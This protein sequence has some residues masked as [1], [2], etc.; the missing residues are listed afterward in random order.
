MHRTLY[1]QA[2]TEVCGV[3]S[4][5]EREKLVTPEGIA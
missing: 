5:A 1:S 3:I 4:L 2:F